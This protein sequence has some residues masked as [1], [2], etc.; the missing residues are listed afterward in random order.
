M[1]HVGMRTAHPT[2]PVRRQGQ[3]AASPPHECRPLRAAV[4]SDM[5]SQLALVCSA[6]VLPHVRRHTPW[7]EAEQWRALASECCTVH[8]HSPLCASRNA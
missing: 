5:A 6:L 8:A 4:T 7:E 3:A 2:P 1:T